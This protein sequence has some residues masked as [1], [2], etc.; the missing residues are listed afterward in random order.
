MT[1]PKD[2]RQG[3]KSETVAFHDANGT[4]TADKAKAVSAEITTTFEDGS[5]EVTI[6]DRRAPR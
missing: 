4:P 3:V 1:E 5:K 2:P 6:L